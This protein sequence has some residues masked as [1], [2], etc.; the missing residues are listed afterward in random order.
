MREEPMNYAVHSEVLQ[1]DCA[2][3]RKTSLRRVGEQASTGYAQF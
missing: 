1:F 3:S 2:L